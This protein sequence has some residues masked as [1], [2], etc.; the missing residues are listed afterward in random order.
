MARGG[1]VAATAPWL[2]EVEWL[3]AA[4]RQRRL[5]SL[6]GAVGGRQ[7]AARTFTARHAVAERSGPWS[8]SR[9]A[10]LQWVVLES[11]VSSTSLPRLPSTTA[12]ACP[13]PPLLQRSN[14][15]GVISE[16]SRFGE[17]EARAVKNHSEL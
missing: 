9:P 8:F 13:C 10:V 7:P 16:H 1:R 12:T 2:E 17:M 11:L 15:A 4:R 3:V 6:R 14:D 5:T